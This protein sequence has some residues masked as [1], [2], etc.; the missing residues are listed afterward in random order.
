MAGSVIRVETNRL[1][2]LLAEVVDGRMS[3]DAAVAALT[4][5]PFE[6]LGDVM[7]DHHRSLRCGAG[8]VI[9]GEGKTDEQ[10]LRIVSSLVAKK[11]DVL[12]TRTGPAAAKLVQDQYP[13]ATFD[14]RART[15][16]I[17]HAPATLVGH[18]AIVCAGTSDVAIA[19]E[20]RITAEHLHAA[21]TTHYDCGVAG[22]HR[23]ID[24]LPTLR[25]AHAIVVVAGMEGAL[26]S[27]VAGLVDRPVL[28][29]PTSVGYG[30]SFGGVTALLA[31]LNSCASGLSVVNIDNGF[32]AGFQA[33]MIN[34]LV[35]SGGSDRDYAA[36]ENLK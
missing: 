6:N 19:E 16:Q 22:I 30:A 35:V 27:V 1:R 15:L 11:S 17:L 28:G 18:V 23:L 2:E 8:E 33:A 26:P 3:L 25:N 5:L 29:V 4:H 10:I 14:V 7:V 21:T 9:F 20:A 13:H 34:K 24:Q 31:M 32:G 12:V 36:T